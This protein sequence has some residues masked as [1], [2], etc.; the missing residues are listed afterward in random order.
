M[1]QARAEGTSAWGDGE[2]PRQRRPQAEKLLVKKMRAGA[3]QEDEVWVEWE[4]Q[5]PLFK[6]MVDSGVTGARAFFA[7]LAGHSC[8]PA[9]AP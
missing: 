7:K 3:R 2:L 5:L 6:P 1:R 4:Q 8:A 9:P